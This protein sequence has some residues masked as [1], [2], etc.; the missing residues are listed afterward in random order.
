M[1]KITETQI[2]EGIHV[3]VFFVLCKSYFLSIFWPLP[4]FRMM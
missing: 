1:K 4:S 3:S 2:P